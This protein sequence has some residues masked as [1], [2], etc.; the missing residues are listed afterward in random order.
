MGCAF[1]RPDRAPAALRESTPQREGTP[2]S[3][4]STPSRPRRLSRGESKAWS[5]SFKWGSRSVSR[6][7]SRA[8]NPGC[9]S[10]ELFEALASVALP[11]VRRS[12]CSQLVEKEMLLRPAAGPSNDLS[13]LSKRV[14]TAVD[15]TSGA[16]VEQ[17]LGLAAIME[18][19]PPPLDP[20]ALPLEPLH[21]TCEQVRVLDFDTLA[22]EMNEWED[23]DWPHN[24]VASHMRDVAAV[25]G[26]E[27]ADDE[28]D[29]LVLDLYDVKFKLT[30]APGVVLSVP[31]PTGLKLELGNAGPIKEGAHIQISAPRLRLWFHTRTD[32][33]KLAF[34]KTP[35][36]VSHVHVNLSLFGIINSWHMLK[37]VDK[38]WLD[39]ILTHALAG[40][41][42]CHGDPHYKRVPSWLGAKLGSTATAALDKY[43]KLGD[44]RP[45]SF[46]L[47]RSFDYFARDA[48]RTPEE[49][50]EELAQKEAEYND[51]LDALRRELA[52]ANGVVPP[53]DRLS[54]NAS[55]ASV[56]SPHGELSRTSGL[57]W[58]PSMMSD[59]VL[60]DFSSP[61]AAVA[62]MG[63]KEALSAAQAAVTHHRQTSRTRDTERDYSRRGSQRPSSPAKLSSPGREPGTPRPSRANTL[64]TPSHPRM[65]TSSGVFSSLRRRAHK[66]SNTVAGE[67]SYARD[68]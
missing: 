49:I 8:A 18:A 65:R 15:P 68:K 63:T 28:A 53:E 6:E 31:V 33:V 48:P 60:N 47:G 19:I 14:V 36:V 2:H 21:M 35:K 39:S 30:F 23:F 29:M 42:P 10:A 56:E 51:H 66:R 40:F 46:K 32:E 44:G 17:R 7:V 57:S 34:I 62:G 43:A 20:N 12:L 59:S 45:L 22:R 13:G 1:A 41:G 67:V 58:W 64:A 27:G 26:P 61:G 38:N 55:E 3:E 9:S 25:I 54:R 52:E 50:E 24:F 11:L 4:E 16:S 37:Y 5:G